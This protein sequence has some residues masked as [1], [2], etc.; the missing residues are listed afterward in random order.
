MDNPI[1]VSKPEL[2]FIYKKKKKNMTT[3]IFCCSIGPKC[4]KCKKKKK[5]RKKKG[6][7][8]TNTWTLLVS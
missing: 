2:M 8:E 5:K 1:P 4:Q 7:R 3:D 6:G